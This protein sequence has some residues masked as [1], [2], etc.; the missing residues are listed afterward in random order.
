MQIAVVS[1]FAIL[2]GV[3][4]WGSTQLSVQSS[5]RSFIPDN[6]YLLDTLNKNDKYYSDEG[7]NL[8]ITTEGIM[9]HISHIYSIDLCSFS[10][11]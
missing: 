11:V 1:F 4:T 9:L 3:C 6:S 8:W 10:A 7:A 5:E 2:L